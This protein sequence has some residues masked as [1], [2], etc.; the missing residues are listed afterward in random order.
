MHDNS[1]DPLCPECGAQLPPA[2]P[3]FTVWCPACGWNVDPTG[4][5]AALTP[6][7]RARRDERLARQ[8]QALERMPRDGAPGPSWSAPACAATALATVVNLITIALAGTGVWLLVTGTWPQRV[9]GALEVAVAVAL[10]PRRP[11]IPQR[12]L[13]RAE[14]PALHTV[15]DRVA[16]E[17]GTVPAHLVAVDTRFGPAYSLPGPRGRRVLILG[18]PLWEALTPDQRVAL[19]AGELAHDAGRRRV[20]A[21]W[22]TAALT[23]LAVWTDLFRPGR[24]RQARQDALYTGAGFSATG[25]HTGGS[26]GGLVAL[27][28][29]ITWPLLAIPAY[30]AG[31]THRLLTGLSVHS[32]AQSA[33]AADAAAARVASAESAEGMV[34]ALLLAETAA[35]ALERFSRS[36]DDVW[37]ELRTYLATV[38]ETERARRL[39]LSERQGSATTGDS[40]PPTH[41]RLRAMRHLPHAEPKVAPSPEEAD[42]MDAELDAVRQALAEDLR[43]YY[44]K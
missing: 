32:R 44:G 2:D 27:V 25:P 39:R 16:K 37:R 41:L 43:T 10:R 4:A 15:I 7:E 30:A 24:S 19:I 40:L 21:R 20:S 22:T 5:L 17:L 23:S 34:R 29:M 31:R 12:T 6:T 13:G 1:D 42:A 3:R 9:L 36:A 28:E 14:A 26:A 8:E 35:F 38:P 33:Y 11:R 18:L